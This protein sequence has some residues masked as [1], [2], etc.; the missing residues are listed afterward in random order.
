MAPANI[1]L[2]QIGNNDSA[3]IYAGEWFTNSD[4]DSTGEQ[5]LHGTRAANS[6]AKFIFNGECYRQTQKQTPSE[7]PLG[8]FVAAYG[9]VDQ[10]GASFTYTID[11][12]SAMSVT[13]PAKNPP[14]SNFAL[15]T[16]PELDYGE[17]T[18]LLSTSQDGPTLWLDYITYT[19]SELVRRLDPQ[20][21]AA[22][23]Q[24]TQT[25][26][27][28]NNAL[29]AGTIVLIVLC[30]ILFVV[31][32]VIAGILLHRRRHRWQLNSPEHDTSAKENGLKFDILPPSA[33]VFGPPAYPTH[34]A[35]LS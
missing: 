4:P 13:F 19:G 27:P 20:V 23:Q 8:T 14:E 30:S 11:D 1:R 28:Q 24:S 2:Y 33:S 21:D 9:A 29:P 34:S 35:P 26:S 22:P 18:L 5:S 3:I 25:L 12:G 7:N 32:A 15:F 16:S 17:H 6:N 31:V 10:S